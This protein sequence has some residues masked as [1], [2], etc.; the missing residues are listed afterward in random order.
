MRLSL[1]V[2]MAAVASAAIAAHNP[3]GAVAD[4]AV[5]ALEGE[6][7]VSEDGRRDDEQSKPAIHRNHFIL[8]WSDV[9]VRAYH[10]APCVSPRTIRGFRDWGISGDD[11]A[12]LNP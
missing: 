10:P 9:Q 11:S 2:V 1:L 6:M 5:V 7:A 12:T 4:S 3:S 8:F